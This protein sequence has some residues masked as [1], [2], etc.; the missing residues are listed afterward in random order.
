M[1]PKCMSD[2]APFG[3]EPH[4]ADV[5]RLVDILISQGRTD[6]AARALDDLGAELSGTPR[7]RTDRAVLRAPGWRGSTDARTTYRPC[8]PRPSTTTSCHPTRSSVRRVGIR[9]RAP[10]RRA[11]RHCP[12][13]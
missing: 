4:P 11:G 6:D 8:S 12:A 2:T 13:R 3:L 7:Y 9:R 5:V 1:T 10:G